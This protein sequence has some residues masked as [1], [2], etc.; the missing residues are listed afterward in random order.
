MEDFASPYEAVEYWFAEAGERE[1]N[2]R[3]LIAD[4]DLLFAET[5]SPEER[6]ARLK[7]IYLAPQDVDDLLQAIR[8]RAVTGLAGKPE[9]LHA[10]S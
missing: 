6:V 4:I 1:G 9:P 2:N 7:G 10:P 3:D 8:H 5:T